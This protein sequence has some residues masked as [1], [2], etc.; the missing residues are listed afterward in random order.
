MAEGIQQQLG[1]ALAPVS[2]HYAHLAAD[3]S[4]EV[5]VYRTEFLHR[6]RIY[7]VEHLDPNHPVLFFVGFAP[8]E[9]AYLLTGAPESF[10]RMARADSVVIDSPDLAV[11]YA[12]AYLEVTRSMSELCYLVRSADQVEFRPNLDADEAAARTAFLRTYRSV[13][14]PP[15]AAATDHGYTV[16]AYTVRDQTLE[17]HSLTVRRDGE[18][19]DRVTVL[20]ADLP[21]TYGL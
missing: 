15:T 21:L 3:P 18:I 12:A 19:D 7:R 8:G 5:E 4:T 9:S 16:T 14:T 11:E 13:I 10:V 1:A 2:E 20:E 6:F 17:R